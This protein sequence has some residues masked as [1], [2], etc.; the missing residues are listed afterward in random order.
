MAPDSLSI[1]IGGNS[2]LQKSVYRLTCIGQKASELAIL[3]LEFEGRFLE[4][5]SDRGLKF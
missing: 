2:P 1:I 4:N 5:M 3:S